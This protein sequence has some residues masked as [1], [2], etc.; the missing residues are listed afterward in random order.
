MRSRQERDPGLVDVEARALG[1]AYRLAQRR[2]DGQLLWWWRLIADP[3]DTR[4]PCRL[5]RGQALSYMEGVL[6][7]NVAT[8]A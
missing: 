3:S 4:Q 8:P 5:E 7:R 2:L 6:Q 1:A